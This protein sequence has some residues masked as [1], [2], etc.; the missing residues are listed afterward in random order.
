MS[1]KIPYIFNFRSEDMVCSGNVVSV[2][3]SMLIN[4]SVS[5]SQERLFV[6]P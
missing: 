5:E 6:R 2:T 1:N 4:F 3:E